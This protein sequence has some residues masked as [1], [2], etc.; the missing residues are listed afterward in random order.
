MIGQKA[1]I[2]T[3]ESWRPILRVAHLLTILDHL[4]VNFFCLVLDTYNFQHDTGC[5]AAVI[6]F[7]FI[8]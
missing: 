4:S 2:F 1:G 6:N 5:H 3:H 8:F 7:F